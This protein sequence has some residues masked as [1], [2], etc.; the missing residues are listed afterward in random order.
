MTIH[1]SRQMGTATRRTGPGGGAAKAL[2]RDRQPG[3]HG[4]G[5]R[6]GQQP[7]QRGQRLRHRLDHGRPHGRAGLP[8]PGD[9]QLPVLLPVGDHQ[10]RG[11]GDDRGPVAIL[12]AARTRLTASP[13]GWVHQPVAPASRPGADTAIAS[14][15]EGTSDTTCRAGQ[16]DRVPEVIP[17]HRHQVILS[18]Q[19]GAPVTP[20]LA[21]APETGRGLARLSRAGPRHQGLETVLPTAAAF[22]TRGRVGRHRAISGNRAGLPLGWR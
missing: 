12:G 16:L 9:I 13:A 11:Q 19:P 5:Q 2:L 15:S 4:Q 8:Q 6:P 21:R 10:V 20:V 3:R 1:G 14:V 18:E 22:T 7:P 17:S